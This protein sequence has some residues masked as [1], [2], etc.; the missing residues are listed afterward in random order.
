MTDAPASVNL[1]RFVAFTKPAARGS[2]V[3]ADSYIVARVFGVLRH[4]RPYRNQE[5]RQKTEE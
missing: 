5:S 4:V 3:N 2:V 1:V